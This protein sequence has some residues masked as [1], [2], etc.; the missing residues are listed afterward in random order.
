M[1]L[2]KPAYRSDASNENERP[3][4]E[5]RPATT[6]DKVLGIVLGVTLAGLVLGVT[7]WLLG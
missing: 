5:G 1:T 6:R 3:F 7:F 2:P 4:V